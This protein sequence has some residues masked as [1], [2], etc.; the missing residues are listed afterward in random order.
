MNWIKR[1]LSKL[2][3]VGFVIATSLCGYYYLASDSSNQKLGNI[4]GGL[5][6][7]LLIAIISF[8]INID[9]R[10]KLDRIKAL[11]VINVLFHRADEDYYRKLIK[12]AKIQIC[13]MGVTA[14]RLLNDFANTESLDTGK[15][16]LLEA[17]NR[18][19]S[20]KILLPTKENLVTENDKNNYGTAK[21][22]MTN[23]NKLYPNDFQFRYFNHNAAHS[24][25]T[26]D[27]ESII[28]P[29]IPEI[30]SKETPGIHVLNSSKYAQTY[31]TYFKKEWDNAQA[32]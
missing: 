7:G 1:N 31:L 5:F 19:V 18:N 3:L 27:D 15:R 6:T 8:L 24:I 2:I 32:V 4:L 16:V 20:V 22:K 25:F 11:K 10:S 26:V 14:F 23:L 12:G 30:S 29:V 21:D 17:L 13:I 28:G 9:E